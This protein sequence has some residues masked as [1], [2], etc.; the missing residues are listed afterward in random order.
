[1]T[2]KILRDK[3]IKQFDNAK[4]ETIMGE[5]TFWRTY[6]RSLWDENRKERWN[7]TVGRVVNGVFDVLRTHCITHGRKWDNE[8][9]ERTARDMFHRILNFKFTPPGRGL[10]A[11]GTDAV[12][13]H[14]GAVLNNCAFLSTRDPQPA[15]FAK[16]M[17]L[18]MLGVGV[19]YDTLGAGKAVIIPPK[20]YTGSIYEIPDTRQ[21]WVDSVEELLNLYM[22]GGN[23]FDLQFDYSKIRKAG[24]PIK[25]FGG[26][27]SGPEPLK[28]LHD[29]LRELCVS[30]SGKRIDSTFI[31]DCC[32]LIGRCV[33]AGNV[34]RSAQIALGQEG[35]RDFL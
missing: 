4:F 26:V 30:Y 13:A 1:M 16:L 7:E 35:D 23:V 22:C 25:R 27:S 2:N 8:R 6:S 18:T 31:V 3:Y 17:N 9:A 34:R 24:L 12:T 19:G 33:V 5:V 20:P 32:N 21:G 28:R 10:Y 14:G 11:M 29:S 15:V